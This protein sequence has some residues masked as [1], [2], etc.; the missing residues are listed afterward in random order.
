MSSVPGGLTYDEWYEAVY[1]KLSEIQ[2]I[3]TMPAEYKP[4][5][6]DLLQDLYGTECP[7]HDAVHTIKQIIETFKE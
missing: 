3:K 6:D 2:W 4:F 1:E 5:I 7:V